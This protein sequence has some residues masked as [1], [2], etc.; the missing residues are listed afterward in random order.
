[1]KFVRKFT[2]SHFT[3]ILSSIYFHVQ[4]NIYVIFKQNF[5][6]R[7]IFP[8]HGCVSP[9]SWENMYFAKMMS[10]LGDVIPSAF[11]VFLT[12]RKLQQH[13]LTSC[14]ILVLIFHYRQ[15]VSLIYKFVVFL[16]REKGVKRYSFFLQNISISAFQTW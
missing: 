6:L 5:Q 14:D 12:A 11:I 7:N 3:A 4:P 9:S 15:T 8:C 1:M 16:V 13:F 10:I 2:L